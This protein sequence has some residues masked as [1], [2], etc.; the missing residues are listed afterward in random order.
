MESWSFS[1]VTC[2]SAHTN[3]PEWLIKIDRYP[4]RKQQGYCIPSNRHRRHELSP[5]A[6]NPI[7]LHQ[8]HVVVVT[9]EDINNASLSRSHDITWKIRRNFTPHKVSLPS[10]QSLSCKEYNP[11]WSVSENYGILLPFTKSNATILCQNLDFFGLPHNQDVAPK[12][13]SGNGSH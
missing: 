11:V 7:F 12:I 4:S 2:Y 3:F 9:L 6:V 10:S 5:T 8:P 1:L 13:T